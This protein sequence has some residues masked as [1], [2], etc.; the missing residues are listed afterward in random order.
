MIIPGKIRSMQRSCPAGNF[1]WA[2]VLSE[3]SVS[4]FEGYFLPEAAKFFGADICVSAHKYLLVWCGE[5]AYIVRKNQP[6]LKEKYHGNQ[7]IT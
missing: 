1:F 7:G 3:K 5:E 4:T 6:F 2:K